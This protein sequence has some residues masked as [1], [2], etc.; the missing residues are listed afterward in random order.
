M[1]HVNRLTA[2]VVGQFQK[3]VEATEHDSLFKLGSTCFKKR[4]QDFVEPV[5]LRACRNETRLVPA[6]LCR[7]HKVLNDGS[8][9]AE[10]F[11]LLPRRSYILPFN[12]DGIWSPTLQ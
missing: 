1:L 10:L 11:K 7:L 9:S 4:R 3:I 12:P 8:G 5:S 2:N 6:V